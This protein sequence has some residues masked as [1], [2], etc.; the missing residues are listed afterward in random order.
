MKRFGLANEGLVAVKGSFE[1]SEAP[2]DIDVVDHDCAARPRGCPSEVYLEADVLFG[3]KTV[4]NEK[5]D[6]AQFEKVGT[7]RSC[8][9][10]PFI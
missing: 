4:A 1:G 6:L 8:S 9:L 10:E 7:G 3:M 2:I 5:I